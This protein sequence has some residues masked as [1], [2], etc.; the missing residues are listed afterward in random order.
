M[1]CNNLTVRATILVVVI[2]AVSAASGVS[3]AQDDPSQRFLSPPNRDLPE[4]K[5]PQEFL[6]KLRSL[7]ESKQQQQ[8]QPSDSSDALDRQPSANTGQLDQLRNALQRLK[9]QLPPG[10]VPPDLSA[11][12]PEQLKKTLE[13]PAVQQQMRDLL[14]QF[15]EDG[16]L[17][18]SGAENGTEVPLPEPPSS[19]QNP[20]RRDRNPRRSEPSPGDQPQKDNKD[21]SDGGEDRSQSTLPPASMKS[22]QDFLQR[23]A[24]NAGPTE[25][26]DSPS[27]IQSPRP[28]TMQPKENDSAPKQ[29]R[30]DSAQVDRTDPEPSRS[31]ANRPTPDDSVAPMPFPGSRPIPMPGNPDDVGSRISDPGAKG[32][33]GE[34]SL[35]L[36]KDRLNDSSESPAE[37]QQRSIKALQELLDQM[38]ESPQQPPGS[39]AAAE[40]TPRSGLNP[41]QSGGAGTPP[42]LP[43]SSQSPNVRPPVP[44]T[45]AP[46]LMSTPPSEIQEQ[47]ERNGFADTFKKLVEK[48][49]QESR[50]P[51]PS[52]SN[53]I[54]ADDSGQA[55]SGSSSG[56]EQS[57]IRMLDGMKDD[58]VEIAKEGKFRAPARRSESQPRQQR[59][60]RSSAGP[61]SDSA[62]S[63]IRKA[64]SDLFAGPSQSSQGNTPSG[65]SSSGF[66]PSPLDVQFDLTPVAVLSGLLMASAA[67]FFGLR[68][69][70]LQSATET[71]RR[72]DATP[73]APNEIQNRADVI[74]AFHEFAMRSTKSVQSWWTHRAVERV[75]ITASPEKRAA[76]ETL[77]NAYEMARYLPQ[78]V[79][80]TSEQIQSTRNALQ[81]CASGV[82]P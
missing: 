58:L 78:E 82:Q 14:K 15:S 51:K 16:V 52:G 66:S 5:Q 63:R 18:P 40:V 71:N 26:P 8:R 24:E 20:R 32:R 75:M 68:F 21:N 36:P 80:L 64:A 2:V 72:A 25:T 55:E 57:M 23:L 34:P 44:G 9:E 81:Q 4:L 22:L 50:Q 41:L 70:K 65:G 37:V 77:T 67:G 53:S 49:K 47:L 6:K 3:P 39:S 54:A 17:P 56:L 42:K 12:P 31:G 74:R 69:L 35:R 79:H 33:A 11:V 7:I 59:S 10:F 43:Q 38:A 1:S 76:V 19:N 62:L 61:P 30:S 13:N 48:A 46:D 28:R 45:A 27:A 60:S 29:R 73:I